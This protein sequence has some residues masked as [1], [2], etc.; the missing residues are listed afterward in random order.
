MVVSY[1]EP[2]DYL[3]DR[4]SQQPANRIM[5]HAAISTD[6]I[7]GPAQVSK[8]RVRHSGAMRDTSPGP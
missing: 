7:E 4:V 3:C 1:R 6:A 5:L 2:L 8:Q